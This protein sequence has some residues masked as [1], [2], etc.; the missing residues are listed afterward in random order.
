MNEDKCL[1]IK[2]LSFGY[3]KQ[4]E[5]LQD[6]NLSLND[7]EILGILGASG[8]GKSSLL[9][10]IAGLEKPFRGEISYLNNYLN[11]KNIFIPPH[12]RGIGLVIQDKGLFPHLNAL[13]NVKFGVLGTKREK[14]D[15][16]MHYLKLLK[17]DHFKLSM[18]NSLS[19]GEQQR[20]AIARA[21]APEPKLL[22]MDEPFS[23]LDSDL[24]EKLRSETRQLFKETKTSCIIVS[25]DRDDA[26]EFCDSVK[27]LKDRQ[28]KEIQI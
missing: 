1:L 14:N 11:N 9:R 2:N 5:I 28:L 21:M 6:I 17:A 18:P 15:I 16:A 4:E 23:S 3:Q 20:V 10:L 7:G 8:I 25:H 24:R 19:G 13:D 27:Q 22:L 12:K 26:I